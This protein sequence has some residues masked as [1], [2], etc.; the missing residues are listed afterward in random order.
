MSDNK[1]TVQEFIDD[2]RREAMNDIDPERAS[3]LL[4]RLSALLGS[5]N[6]MYINAEMEYNRF[7]EQMTEKY[8]K[9]TE[10]RA[11]AKAS[12]HYEHMLRMEGLQ[13]VVEQL[14]R[15]MKYVIKVKLQEIKE[16]RYHG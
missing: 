13:D 6:D 2:I 5:V 10:A 9:V 16:V 14:I 11:K 8:E 12:E 3:V 7:Y 4:N 1:K 15:S